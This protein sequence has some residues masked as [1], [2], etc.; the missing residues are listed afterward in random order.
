[1]SLRTHPDGF[2]RKDIF[3]AVMFDGEA[4]PHLLMF[5]F[6]KMLRWQWPCGLI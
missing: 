5:H 1:M 6:G 4:R 3:V 2:G